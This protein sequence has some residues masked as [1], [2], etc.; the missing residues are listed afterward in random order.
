[1]KNKQ[2]IDSTLK[3]RTIDYTIAVDRMRILINSIIDKSRKYFN[4]S[5]LNL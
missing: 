5:K 3:Y 4:I 2:Y 1:M